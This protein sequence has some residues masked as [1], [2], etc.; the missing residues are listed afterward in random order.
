M[1][2]LLV[3]SVVAPVSAGPEGEPRPSPGADVDA[4]GTAERALA[5]ALRDLGHEV[6]YAGP[7]QDPDRLAAAA[8]QEDVDAVVLTDDAGAADVVAALDRRGAGDVVVCLAT[9]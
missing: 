1:S 9:A 2:R 3:S 6:V 5:R 8:A 4:G 7:D